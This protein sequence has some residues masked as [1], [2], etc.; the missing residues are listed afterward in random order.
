MIQIGKWNTLTVL[1]DT[2]HGLFLGDEE[3]GE[4][5]L[6]NKYSPKDAKEGDEL[7]VFIYRDSEQRLIATSLRPLITLN[8]FAYLRVT[9]VGTVGAFLDWGLEK[10]LFVPHRLQEPPMEVGRRYIVHMFLDQVTDRLVA[11]NRYRRFLSNARMELE[12]GDE[13]GLLV[14][15]ETPVGYR[16]IVNNKHTGMLY[17]SDLYRP[18]NLG[19]R[20]TGFVKTIR[21]DGKLD[22]RLQAEGF[23]NIETQAKVLLKLLR[24]AGGKLEFG[25]KSEPED[26]QQALQMSKKTFKRAAGTLM[27]LRLAVIHEYKIVLTETGKTVEKAGN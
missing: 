17:S 8:G 9:D 12:E 24:D 20:L 7:T 19:D 4:V 15:E 5:L 2:K 23:E 18:L 1:R 22:L 14:M 3:G 26:I 16:A 10:E 27:R 6:P 11:T 25:D 21:E 13:V